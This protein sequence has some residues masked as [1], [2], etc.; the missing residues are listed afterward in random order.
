[1]SAVGP[2][3]LRA[4]A[5]PWLISCVAA[6][7]AGAGLCLAWPL[8]SL[9]ASSGVGARSEGDRALFE[10]GGYLLLEVARVQGPALMATAQGL[11]PLLGVSLVLTTLCNALLLVGLNQSERLRWSELLRRALERTPQLL[12]ITAGAGLAQVVLVVIGSALVA[13]LPEPLA[14]PVAAT[15]LQGGAWLVVAL[16]M[17]AVGGTSDVAKASLVR[18]DVRLT[19]ALAHAAQITLRRPLLSAWGFVPYSLPFLLGVALAARLTEAV[20]VSKT[21]WWRVLAVF[22]VHQLVIVLAVAMRAAWYARTLRLTAT[23]AP[24]ST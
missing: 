8:A 23:L 14:K 4:R 18:N 21:G 7:R 12:A 1:M 3:R 20:D 10:A 5:H 17:G 19:E 24:Q 22:V 2:G 16:S 13:A 9:L 15:L 11:L 6:L